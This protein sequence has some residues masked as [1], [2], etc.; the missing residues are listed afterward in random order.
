MR[1]FEN[2]LGVDYQKSLPTPALMG[3][4]RPS[5]MIESNRMGKSFQNYSNSHS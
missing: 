3:S 5:T 4:V 1:G 2:S